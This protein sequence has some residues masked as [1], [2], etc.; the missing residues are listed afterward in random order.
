MSRMQVPEALRDAARIARKA[1]WRITR[2]SGGHLKWAPP[3]GR[4]V[5]TSATPKGGNRSAENDLALLRKEGLK[6]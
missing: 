4:F 3:G 1:G 5:V 6:C 2:T